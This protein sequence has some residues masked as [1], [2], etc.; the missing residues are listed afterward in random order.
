M[1]S[2]N[3][4]ALVLSSA[5]NNVFDWARI[6]D[7]EVTRTQVNGRCQDL[8]AVVGPLESQS[9]DGATSHPE[10][11]F[12][13]EFLHRSVRDFLQQS[14]SVQEKLAESAGFNFE[15]NLTLLSC[16]IALLK[17]SASLMLPPHLAGMEKVRSWATEALLDLRKIDTGHTASAARLLQCL[18]TTMQCL[19]PGKYRAHWSN[20]MSLG[21]GPL[22]HCNIPKSNLAERGNRDLTGHLIEFGLTPFVR[23]ALSVRKETKQGRPYLDYALRYDVNAAF[24]SDDLQDHLAQLSGDPAMVEM[25]L[26]L[27][28][29]VNEPIHI[30]EGRTV[31]DLYLAFLSDHELRHERYRKI[32]WMLIEHGARPIRTCVVGKQEQQTTDRYRDVTFRNA[33]LSMREILSSAF[34][35]QEAEDMCERTA[36]NA[37]GG[38]WWGWVNLWKPWQSNNAVA[39]NLGGP[40]AG[41]TDSYR[42]VT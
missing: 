32:T 17:K 40:C 41:I 30:Y 1:I 31:W 14:A 4:D 39:E 23:D 12:R 33:E 29:N 35:D 9:L 18:D 27:G 34:G 42:G 28:C 19:S 2:S 8:L 36:R 3:P 16:Y 5:I 21:A 15:V 20:V 22:D 24:R 37:V 38:G 26:G 11:L 10:A 13:I 7:I 6:E 25:L